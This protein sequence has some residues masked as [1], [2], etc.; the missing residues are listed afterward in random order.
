MHQEDTIRAYL[1]NRLSP[2]ATE[3]FKQEIL[4]D[5]AL[6]VRVRRIKLQ[7]MGEELVAEEH[8]SAQMKHWEEDLPM[9]DTIPWWR[10]SRL[11]WLIALGLVSLLVIWQFRRP[12]PPA[13]PGSPTSTAPVATGHDQN[14]TAT[15]PI[16]TGAQHA[17]VPA[18]RP[19]L[20][21]WS[22]SVLAIR[23]VQQE[24]AVAMRSQR[25]GSSRIQQARQT[26]RDSFYTGVV[27]RIDNRPY[28]LTSAQGLALALKGA[29]AIVGYGADQRSYGLRLLGKDELLGLAVLEFAQQSPLPPALGLADRNASDNIFMLG[30]PLSK[31]VSS[32][33]AV[34]GKVRAVQNGCLLLRT[35]TTTPDIDGPVLNAAGQVTGFITHFAAAAFPDDI[36]RQRDLCAVGTAWLLSVT[37]SIITPKAGPKPYIGLGFE[38]IAGKNEVKIYKV[39]PESPA[40]PYDDKLLNRLVDSING[41]PISNLFD[42]AAAL[43]HITPKTP[44]YLAYS[45]PG[46]AVKTQIIYSEPLNN[47]ALETI[48]D[49]VVEDWPGFATVATPGLPQVEYKGAALDHDLY[50]V[51]AVCPG[52]GPCPYNVLTKADL[53]AQVQVLTM[54][55]EVQLRLYH[56]RSNKE[57]DHQI[58]LTTHRLCH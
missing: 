14:N 13:P 6:A 4:N 30:N 56:A 47:Q 39:L 32:R 48:A 50:F 29:G 51:H 9:P 33:T 58:L 10:S 20:S 28:V 46:G 1:L 16:D 23:V 22:A 41:Q 12:Q 17:L 54:L 40:S 53:G 5:P 31:T 27:V 15:L 55:N 18:P 37:R 25:V 19:E 8:L 57:T 2:E 26:H 44:V 34:A 42:V 49:A 38:Q 7:L 11:M 52:A 21:G 3:A 24:T 43:R 36:N 35:S 45:A